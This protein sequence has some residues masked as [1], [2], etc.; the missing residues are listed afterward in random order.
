MQSHN[1][2]IPTY[3]PTSHIEGYASIQ[4]LL[5]SHNSS[6]IESRDVVG[7][8]SHLVLNYQHTHMH[9][10]MCACMHSGS[11][12]IRGWQCTHTYIR[13]SEMSEYPK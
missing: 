9:T 8:V 11:G 4:Y 2:V 10:R 5:Q 6:C 1:S 13:V 12:G 3:I 7:M